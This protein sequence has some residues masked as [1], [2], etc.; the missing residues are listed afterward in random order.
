M[1]A[2][3]DTPSAYD[4]GACAFFFTKLVDGI[5]YT[6]LSLLSVCLFPRHQGALLL[7]FPY[8]PGSARLLTALSRELQS[9]QANNCKAVD[10]SENEA[11]GAGARLSSSGVTTLE[12]GFF[13]AG[14]DP[15]GEEA[16]PVDSNGEGAAKRVRRTVCFLSCRYMVDA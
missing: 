8:T 6:L 15:E 13:E 7:L 12:D 10:S 9:A 2:N 16:P 1:T 5:P 4:G 14:D 11:G 3:S